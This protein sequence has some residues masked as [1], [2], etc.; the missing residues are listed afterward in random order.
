M[1]PIFYYMPDVLILE[2]Y[3]FCCQFKC[4]EAILGL[5]YLKVIHL[6]NDI[7]HVELTW[8][9]IC[10]EATELSLRL[11]DMLRA[12]L[13]FFGKLFDGILLILHHWSKTTEIPTGIWQKKI[14]ALAVN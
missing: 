14:S 11:F 13:V 1:L 8:F 12:F 6:H 10:N 3:G 4:F 2:L 9:V 5:N 7:H